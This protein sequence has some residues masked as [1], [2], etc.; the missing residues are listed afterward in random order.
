VEISL[1]V[2]T[3]RKASET[4]VILTTTGL[5]SGNVNENFLLRKKVNRVSIDG[6]VDPKLTFPS[7]G[8]EDASNGGFGQSKKKK[9]GSTVDLDVYDAED[10]P[11]G[12][13][14]LKHAGNGVFFGE[15]KGFCFMVVPCVDE[16][17]CNDFT[18]TFKSAPSVNDVEPIDVRGDIDKGDSAFV[19][20]VDEDVANSYQEGMT[21]SDIEE[22]FERLSEI[23]KIPCLTDIS[24]IL[25]DE[26]AAV[27]FLQSV[28][29]IQKEEMCNSCG[30]EFQ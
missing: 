2:F 15:S 8:S 5:D 25:M 17:G 21:Y 30:G 16:Y 13:T 1:F 4:M 14:N 9:F 7:I 6:S 10:L 26:A 28:R 23:K 29:V 22:Q 27:R 3:K 19:M 11:D 20:R 12:P 24:S 18:Q